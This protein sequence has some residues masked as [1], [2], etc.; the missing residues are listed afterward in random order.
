MSV[1][2]ALWI[3]AVVGSC[4]PAMLAGTALGQIAAMPL[5]VAELPALDPH[6]TPPQL[7]PDP[8]VVLGGV[9]HP[10]DDPDRGVPG[11]GAPSGG[12]LQPFFTPWGHSAGSGWSWQW[13]PRGRI[14]PAYLADL[15]ESRMGIELFSQRSEGWLMQA[16]IGARVGIARF[17]TDELARPEGYQFDLEAASFPRVALGSPNEYVGSDFRVGMPV[18]FRRGPIETKLGYY[19]YCSHLGDSYIEN[20][21][22]ILRRS[23]IR[24]ALVLALGFRPR[25]ALR[26]YVEADYAFYV[27]GN[28]EPWQ[29]QFGGEWSTLHPTGVRG[30][31]FLAVHGQIRQDVDFGGNFTVQTGWQWR[32][33]SGELFR[34][35]FHYFNGQS[36]QGQFYDRFEEHIGFGLWYDF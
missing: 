12:S 18:G 4:W 5:T 29:F 34:A 7:P 36:D 22:G 1:Q 20:H 8:G 19:H 31:P 14:Y 25:E 15:R 23:Y 10:Q 11:L 26:L 28:S 35:G 3:A 2:R 13:F 33:R 9:I 32:G 27:C 21:P 16:T 17:G 24:D 6:T 30:A